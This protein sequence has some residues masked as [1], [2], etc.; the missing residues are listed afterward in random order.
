MVKPSITLSIKTNEWHRPAGLLQTVKGI[1]AIVLNDHVHHF[2]Q[3]YFFRIKICASRSLL[4]VLDVFLSSTK[5]TTLF[6]DAGS[7]YP[8][9]KGAKCSHFGHEKFLWCRAMCNVNSL[10]LSKSCDLQ[11]GINLANRVMLLWK[12]S[13]R[14]VHSQGIL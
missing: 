2:Y 11:R 7:Q 3:V 10:S 14:K 6:V 13:P 5:V 1:I 9:H 4:K 8:N 12:I